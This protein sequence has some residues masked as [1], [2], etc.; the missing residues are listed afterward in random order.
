MTSWDA[1]FSRAASLPHE[2]TLE[3]IEDETFWKV[4]SLAE[5]LDELKPW[6]LVARFGA[7]RAQA[8]LIARHEIVRTS[9][10]LRRRSGG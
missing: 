9:W 5:L 7:A 8:Q 10:Q 2:D 4:T 3:I 6:C 1:W